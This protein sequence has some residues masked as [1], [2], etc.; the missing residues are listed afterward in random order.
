M[1]SMLTQYHE[2]KSVIKEQVSENSLPLD[3][4]L[5]MQELD[6]RIGVLETFQSLSKTAPISMDAKVLVQH[7]QVVDVCI[8]YLLTD[9]KFGPVTDESGKKKRETA[10]K[11]LQDMIRDNQKRFTSFKA[12]TQDH[13]KKC[14]SN[15]VNTI[16]P[17]WLQY[18][19]TYI[20]INLQEA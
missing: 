13:Y 12:E 20:T 4:L 18:R 3:E 16:L 10:Q 7:Y 9:H 8:R 17:M 19:D 1:A 6:Y 11:A 15:C 2:R 5:Q 14:I